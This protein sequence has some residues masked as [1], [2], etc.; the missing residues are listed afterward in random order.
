MNGVAYTF[1]LTS[2]AHTTQKDTTQL[3]LNPTT[4]TFASAPKL[5]ALKQS[6]H[7][8]TETSEISTVIYRGNPTLT[9]CYITAPFGV[10]GCIADVVQVG[11]VARVL[12]GQRGAVIDRA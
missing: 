9:H 5:L 11:P 8:S 7:I 10:Q 1:R 3:S 2:A 4:N 12:V 6:T